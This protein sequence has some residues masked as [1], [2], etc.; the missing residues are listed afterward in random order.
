MS[1]LRLSAAQAIDGRYVAP[2]PVCRFCKG[3]LP[4]DPYSSPST[5]MNAR[6]Y[7]D[8]CNPCR[9]DDAYDYSMETR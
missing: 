6:F 8:Q 7:P 2:V 4:D 3:P 1:L 9:I 5:L